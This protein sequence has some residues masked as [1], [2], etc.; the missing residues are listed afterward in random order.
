MTTFTFPLPPPPEPT[1]DPI[2][3]IVRTARWSERLAAWVRGQP[4]PGP[5]PPV[6][7]LPRHADGRKAQI[8]DGYK[9]EAEWTA[10]KLYDAAIRAGEQPTKPPFPRP[11]RQHRGADIMYWIPRLSPR[12]GLKRLPYSTGG[13]EIPPPAGEPGGFDVPALA[14]EAGQVVAAARLSTGWWVALDIGNGVGLAHHH[15][16]CV[17]VERGQLVARGQPLGLVGGSPVGYGLWHLHFDRA[18]RCRFDRAALERRGRL[19]GRFVDPAPY[20]AR[21]VHLTLEQAWGEAGRVGDGE[22]A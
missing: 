17:L 18:E 19:D 7:P 1:E 8:S 4:P 13:Y 14:P 3:R 15:L 22:A 10:W 20:L 16:R 2:E 5:P 21:A 9:S 11:P 12:R 6:Y